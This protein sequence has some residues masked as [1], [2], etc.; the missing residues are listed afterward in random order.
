MAYDVAS[1]CP[2]VVQSGSMTAGGG[3]SVVDDIHYWRRRI[4]H[5]RSVVVAAP[6]AV[7]WALSPAVS[8]MEITAVEAGTKTERLC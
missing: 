8:D 4:Y 2:G 5:T 6:V 3:G 1:R 7:G